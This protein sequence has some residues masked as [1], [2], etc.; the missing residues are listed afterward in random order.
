MIC[1]APGYTTDRGGV[2][3]MRLIARLPD[4]R[5]A[6]ALIDSLRN[7]GFDRDDM[8]VSNPADEK[9]FHSVEE[10]TELGISMIKTE[11]NGLNDMGTFAEGIKGLK[12]HEGIII[13]VKTPK[14]AAA[15]VR[16]IMEQ[17]GAVEILQD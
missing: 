11:R 5:Q 12:G 4:E 9:E 15:R 17:S 6:S 1:P 7:A 3:N 8:I 16:E 10:A 14:K 13:A 2:K